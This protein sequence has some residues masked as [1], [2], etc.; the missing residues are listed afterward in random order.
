MGFGSK[1]R[2]QFSAGEAELGLA[3]G[4]RTRGEVRTLITCRRDSVSS[5]EGE[6][7]SDE[8]AGGIR[9]DTVTLITM[10]R[11]NDKGEYD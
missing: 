8:F 11:V 9:V 4:L 2:P 5:S 6:W 3:L 10:S 1:S 7:K